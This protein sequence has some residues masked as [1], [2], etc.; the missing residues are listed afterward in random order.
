MAQSERIK[1]I[2]AN[3]KQ[4]G[5]NPPLN[6]FLK[7]MH[8]LAKTKYRDLDQWEKIARS[9]AGAIVNQKI[10]IEPYDKIIGRV[11]HLNREEVKNPDSDFDC[12]SAPY[13]RLCATIPD[14]PELRENQLSGS[15]SKGHITWMWDKILKLG[16]SGMKER[17][18]KALANAADG[19]GR[20]FFSGVLIMVEALEKWNEKHV[21]ELDHLGMHEMA[22]L[23][24]RVPRYPA[25]TFLEAVQSFFMQ[26]IVTMSEN[27]YGGNGPGRLD[28]YLW[29]YLER[30][31]KNNDC[32]LEQ[33]RELIE[34][35][36]IRIDERIHT[37]D[38]WV[39]AI[40]VGGSHPNGTSAVN[41]LSR[42]MVE[43]IMD[44]DITHPAVYIRLPKDKPQDFVRL[45]AKYLQNGSNRAQILCDETIVKALNDSGV[46]YRDAVE[47]TCGGCMEIG[48]QG[49]NSDFLF[50]GWHNITKIAEL[51][52]TGGLC[53]KTNKKLNAVNA[54]G[55]E[56]Y[57][58]FE[59]FYKDFIGEV[60]RILNIFFKA[61]DAYSEEAE[62]SRPAYLISS[63][64][65]DCYAK[66]RN[67]H[68]GGA[69][70]HDYGSCPLGIPNTADYLFAVKK[71]V[72]EES[73][74]TPHELIESLKV[75]FQGFD[76][77]RKK[78]I[79]IPKYG[80]ENE[81][82]DGFA[83]KTFA[84]IS[85]IY[86]SYKTRWGGTGKMVVLTFVWAPEAGRILGATADGN[87]AG[88]P[89]AHG[90]T[91]QS[92]SMTNGITSSM[93]SCTSIPFH[94]FNGGA[95]TMWDLD[96]SWAGEDVIKAL[97]TTFFE[98][99]GQIF[100]GNMMDAESLLKAQKT[101]E[102][103]KHLIVRVGGYSARFVNLKKDLQSEII[104]RMRHA[105]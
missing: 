49:M 58:S 5:G 22:E 98:K 44:L 82:A 17:Y 104:A 24:R 79:S 100:Q 91:P 4:R 53:L 78:L 26:Y 54:K 56:S 6:T 59:D 41:P 32:T 83:R 55:L 14:Y 68:G 69:R 88:K 39:E 15:T 23:C 36:F 99:G 13:K 63:M 2:F 65:E 38:G 89:V 37:Q 101:P 52:V 95:S 29:P 46:T 73:I 85:N 9:M 8:T 45:C 70:Y 87:L 12:L 62:N 90:V 42:I 19:K 20:Q 40:V 50:N 71:A 84:D 3:A 57:T 21:A 25:D 75:N 11:Y 97:L 60:S 105:G 76:L 43:S 92:S 102:E 64:I 103:N 18:A 47:Y 94:L 80:Q 67:M 7:D 1:R 77:L 51:F 93:N 72:F 61:Q 10:Y 48:I 34:E 35:L 28:Y 74:C 81:E 33:A 30:D 16:T 86:T 31:L 27:P 96:P 66:G